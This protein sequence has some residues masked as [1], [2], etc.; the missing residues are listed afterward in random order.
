LVEGWQTNKKRL[1]IVMKL[2]SFFL[3]SFGL[4]S[5]LG[6]KIGLIVFL[7]VLLPQAILGE[8][9]FY[10]YSSVQTSYKSDTAQYRLYNVAS[11]KMFEMAD[12]IHLSLL[13]YRML[14]DQKSIPI[15][16]DIL[17]STPAS[18]MVEIGSNR[19][20]LQGMSRILDSESLSLNIGTRNTG[21]AVSG[22]LGTKETEG[23][24]TVPEILPEPLDH[25]LWKSVVYVTSKC[26][27]AWP[28]LRPGQSSMGYEIVK[29]ED[30]I[31]LGIAEQAASPRKDSL[32]LLTSI[33]S[34]KGGHLL[35]GILI[36]NASTIADYFHDYYSIKYTTFFV[37]D[38][39]ILTNIPD[40]N[41]L[42]LLNRKA[43]EDVKNSVLIQKD[44]YSRGDLHLANPRI[45]EWYIPLFRDSDEPPAKSPVGILGIGGGDSM[46]TKLDNIHVLF[47]VIALSIAA[48]YFF[49]RTPFTERL[50][51]IELETENTYKKLQIMIESVTQGIL[52]LDEEGIIRLSNNYALKVTE[53]DILLGKPVGLLFQ[54]DFTKILL[55]DLFS[56]NF[57]SNQERIMQSRTSK[58]FPCELTSSYLGIDSDFCYLIVFSDITDRKDA[59]IQ[60]TELAL[61]KGRVSVGNEIHTTLAQYFGMVVSHLETAMDQD[62]PE[63]GYANFKA[64]LKFAKLGR[65]EA[66]ES[67]EALN[68]EAKKYSLFAQTLKQ[69]T[70][71][72]L[73][74]PNL[75]FNFTIQGQERKID[76]YAGKQ[77]LRLA[78]EAVNNVRQHSGAKEL[79]IL[80]EFLENVVQLSIEDNGRGFDVDNPVNLTG[81]GLTEMRERANNIDANFYLLSDPNV[82]TLVKVSYIEDASFEEVD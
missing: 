13:S 20:I 57:H 59:E 21:I 5:N 74:S 48:V 12:K 80:V 28:I 34:S 32:V 51:K 76:P 23:K 42:R 31:C 49:A 10:E 29:Y 22:L 38:R 55:K 4:T 63:E 47:L 25:A 33:P 6:K 41:G 24:V 68:P 27:I 2:K 14:S 9:L 53:Y 78:Q 81:N 15:S 60:R 65:K 64:A 50:L 44:F 71:S 69:S 19:I 3:R 54:V 52:V 58:K 56:G 8:Y 46:A 79:N 61:L 35:G 66:Y 77:L 39:A 1:H 45:R 17:R 26:K 40:L 36:D 62:E 75:K 18:F 43:S 72:L 16:A 11:Q 7:S 70:S 82:G 67:V 73:I 30:L 37:K